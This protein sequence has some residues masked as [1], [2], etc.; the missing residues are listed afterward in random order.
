MILSEKKP[1]AELDMEDHNEDLPLSANYKQFHIKHYNLDMSCD[2][3]EHTFF[4]TVT[5]SITA[6]P[7]WRGETDLV[8][9]CS[10]IEVQDVRA[11]AKEDACE[12]GRREAELETRLDFSQSVWA[13]TISLSASDGFKAR[14]ESGQVIS[15]L[16]SYKTLPKSR[17]LHW[18][19]GCE[20]SPCVYTAAASINNRGLFPCQ[21][22]PAG[23]ATGHV[24]IYRRMFQ[25]RCQRGAP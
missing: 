12:N 2:F 5:L 17:S 21:V 8:L 20:G 6:G 7:E 14:L 16:I 18:R 23:L 15:V 1:F 3:E 25:E 24:N 10:D 9:D 4:S 19:E 13:L 11:V 22:T